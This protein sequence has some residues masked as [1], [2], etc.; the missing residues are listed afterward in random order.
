MRNRPF[1]EIFAFR[2]G[3][4]CP[5]D[6]LR[7]DKAHDKLLR[8]VNVALGKSGNVGGGRIV[9]VAFTRSGS[10]IHNQIVRRP[11]RRICGELHTYDCG[12][13]LVGWPVRT[14]SPSEGSYAAIHLV[15]DI[16]REGQKLFRPDRGIPIARCRSC[17]I[18]Q[19]VAQD[20][21]RF[22]KPVGYIHSGKRSFRC[23]C[24]DIGYLRRREGSNCRSCQYGC[25]TEYCPQGKYSCSILPFKNRSARK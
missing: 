11:I 23:G 4:H 1:F 10:E 21:R 15:P 13:K 5:W 3:A 17:H 9:S 14:C 2:K 7:S 25:R 22:A 18:R 16:A 8:T 12:I 6:V 19:N 24:D 20:Y